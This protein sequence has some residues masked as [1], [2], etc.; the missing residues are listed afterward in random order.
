MPLVSPDPAGNVVSDPTPPSAL[1]SAPIRAVP[2]ALVSPAF[3][4]ELSAPVSELSA[5]VVSVAP[6]R[7]GLALVSTPAPPVYPDVSGR[8]TPAEDVS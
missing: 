6:T 3:R 1:V 2:V 5:P 8:A 7:P 4:E